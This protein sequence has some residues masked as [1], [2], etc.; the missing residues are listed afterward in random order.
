M[1]L[2]AKFRNNADWYTNKDAYKDYIMKVITDESWEITEPYFQDSTATVNIILEALDYHWANLMEKQT[3][4]S[5]YQSYLQLN[6]PFAKF[7]VKF[8]TLARTTKIPEVIQINNLWVKVNFN[9]Q[10]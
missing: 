9:L 4:H 10:S 5:N 6:K 8:Q 3:A 1:S 7:I 2:H